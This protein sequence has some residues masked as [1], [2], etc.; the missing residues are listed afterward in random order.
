[1]FK[2]FGILFGK[3]LN[4]ENNINFNF[5]KVIDEDYLLYFVLVIYFLFY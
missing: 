4:D 3:F 1:M 5:S 2:I